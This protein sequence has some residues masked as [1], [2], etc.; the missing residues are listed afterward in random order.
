[1]RDREQELA[2][3]A[4]RSREC[5]VESHQGGLHIGNY[6]GA[7]KQWVALSQ[8]PENECIF[9]VVD[10][11][12]VTVEYDAKALPKR[13]FEAAAA[14]V[15]GG[16]D[17]ERSIIFTQSDVKEHMELSWYLTTITMMG[18]LN[19]MTQFKEKS[20]QHKE[21]NNAGLFTY[22]ILMAADVLLYRLLGRAAALVTDYS[23]VWT[24]FLVL[25]RPIGFA[26]NDLEDYAGGRGLNVDNLDE[27]LPGPQ[28][29][30]PEQCAAFVPDAVK[31][32]P[33][34]SELRARAVQ[35]VGLAP[36]D[37]SATDRLL[38]ELDRRGLLS[39]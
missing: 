9:C 36:V 11:H 10:A 30:T 20:E 13:V 22:P 17:P 4:L 32:V 33:A 27:L 21:N 39:R 5:G 31:D 26:L 25:D 3:P 8:D 18:E 6:Y 12:A 34:L 16:I 7:L 28:L 1:M 29:L 23:S 14:Y 37:G 2:L 38:E 15:A 35:R 19:R 24:D